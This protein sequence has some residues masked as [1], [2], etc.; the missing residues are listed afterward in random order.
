MGENKNLIKSLR[1]ERIMFGSLMWEMV[2]SKF[3]RR[4]VA[5]LRIG[6]ELSLDVETL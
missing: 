5:A 3:A 4:I 2:M 1:Q 6:N